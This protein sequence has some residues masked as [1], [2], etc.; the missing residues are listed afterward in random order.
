M[1]E[2]RSVSAAE[3]SPAARASVKSWLLVGLLTGLPLIGCWNAD[4]GA[5]KAPGPPEVDRP[6]A[7]YR[8]DDPTA[9]GSDSSGRHW[10]A[11][12]V[13]MLTVKDPE[14]SGVV[15]FDSSALIFLPTV[16]R[17]F[18]VSLWI[19]TQ[20]L[21]PDQQAWTSG[22]R[23]VDADVSGVRLDFGLALTVDKLAYGIGTPGDGSADSMSLKS[24]RGV[25]DGM[26]HHVAIVRNTTTAVP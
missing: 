6:T 2:D 10:D 15:H 5:T 14:R 4:I 8:F 19:K 21:G 9:L 18:T 20:Q 26:W 25:S 24:Q 13:K 23:I 12:A 3:D 11:V 1:V 7:W 17:D 16:Q 22:A